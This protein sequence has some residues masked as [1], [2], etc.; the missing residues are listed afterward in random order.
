MHQRYVELRTRVKKGNQV[1]LQL[2]A[3]EREAPRGIYM[4]WL[5]T[6]TGTPSVAEWVVLR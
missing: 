2:P 6:N 1:E 3:D 4:L 5:I